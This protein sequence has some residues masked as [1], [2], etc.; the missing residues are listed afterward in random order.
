MW[1][2]KCISLHHTC[3]HVL[4]NEL[5]V[6]VENKVLCE[7]GPN[8]DDLNRFQVSQNDETLAM[9][10]V[11]PPNT[12]VSE[13]AVGRPEAPGSEMIDLG[14]VTG[15]SIMRVIYSSAG[16]TERSEGGLKRVKSRKRPHKSRMCFD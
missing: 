12:I 13:L 9:V 16:Q 5:H 14:N 10:F 7:L 4:L 15:L 8:W 3:T 1:K 11:T 6:A 2:R